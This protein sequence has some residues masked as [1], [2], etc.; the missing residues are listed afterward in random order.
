MIAGVSDILL[1][2]HC[3]FEI[4]SV[5]AINRLNG[6]SISVYLFKVFKKVKAKVIVKS[7]FKMICAGTFR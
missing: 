7:S 6:L 3:T 2:R 1:A 4:C 5:Y